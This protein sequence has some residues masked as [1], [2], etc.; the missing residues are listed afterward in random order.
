MMLL[1]AIIVLYLSLLTHL[2]TVSAREGSMAM[3]H[4]VFQFWIRVL[5]TALDYMDAVQLTSHGANRFTLC[6]PC[7]AHLK[8]GGPD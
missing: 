3:C 6:F 8:V 5:E 1:H 7:L 2:T 4:S